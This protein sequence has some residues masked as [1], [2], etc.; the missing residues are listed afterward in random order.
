[1]IL[2]TSIH[3]GGCHVAHTRYWGRE[4]EIGGMHMVGAMLTEALAY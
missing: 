1:M 3:I 2:V 4:G